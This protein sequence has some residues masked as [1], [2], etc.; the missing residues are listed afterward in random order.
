M[1]LFYALDRELCLYADKNG[2]DERTDGRCRY[3]CVGLRIAY[4][5]TI[6]DGNGPMDVLM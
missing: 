5:N 4:C 1:R 6:A 2:T 3:F